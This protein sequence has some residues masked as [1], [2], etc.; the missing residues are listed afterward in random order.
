MR[1]A[2]STIGHKGGCELQMSLKASRVEDGIFSQARCFVV[3]EGVW[4]EG[5]DFRGFVRAV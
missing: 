4:M 5:E 2:K 1:V 3:Q